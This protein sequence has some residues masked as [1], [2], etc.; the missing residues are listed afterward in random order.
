ML[1]KI[2][3]LRTA[4]NQRFDKSG[5]VQAIV[6]ALKKAEKEACND[7]ERRGNIKKKGTIKKITDLRKENVLAK[8]TKR[9]ATF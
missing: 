7:A 5:K 4:I 1:D 6:K 2:K 9:T 3:E 8:G